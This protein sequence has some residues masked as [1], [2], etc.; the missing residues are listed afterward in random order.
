M[1]LKGIKCISVSPQTFFSFFFHFIKW[2]KINKIES[3][4][5]KIHPDTLNIVLDIWE[6]LKSKEF[7]DINE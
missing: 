1:K 4:F 6:N 7:D 2:K 5:P 3:V